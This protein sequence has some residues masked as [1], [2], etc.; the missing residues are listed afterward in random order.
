MDAGPCGVLA[1]L[2]PCT[3]SCLPCA[4]LVRPASSTRPP[5]GKKT[6]LRAGKTANG[7]F[8]LQ[9]VNGYLTYLE[10]RKTPSAV[11]MPQPPRATTP[12]STLPTMLTM[13]HLTPHMQ[14]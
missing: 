2:V 7:G 8:R 12:P 9:F 3:V 14:R 1:P 13:L 6:R 5:D 10:R 4:L 11:V